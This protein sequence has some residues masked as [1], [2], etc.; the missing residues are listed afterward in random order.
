MTACDVA[1]A[2]DLPLPGCTPP[3]RRRTAARSRQ[4]RM[5]PG[6]GHSRDQRSC[7]CR[8]DLERS[9]RRVPIQ[10]ASAAGTLDVRPRRRRH[11]SRHARVTLSP[12]TQTHPQT[13]VGNSQH[14]ASPVRDNP[15][16]RDSHT[17]GGPALLEVRPRGCGGGRPHQP[18]HMTAFAPEPSCQ[19]GD[20][21]RSEAAPSSPFSPPPAMSTAAKPRSAPNGSTGIDGRA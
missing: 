8:R 12:T 16:S 9:C 6:R 4:P 1:H 7:R 10:T 19:F 3:W 2:P 21:I 15:S 5:P 17:G 11:L 14:T 13:H 18:S 20:G